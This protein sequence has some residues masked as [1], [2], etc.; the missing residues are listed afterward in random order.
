MEAVVFVVN[1]VITGL[2]RTPLSHVD[3]SR[4]GTCDQV[5]DQ[6]RPRLAAAPVTNRHRIPVISAEELAPMRI[7]P[8]RTRRIQHVH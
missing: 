5:R 7:G 6:G 4:Q 1:A 2:A 3:S 8:S